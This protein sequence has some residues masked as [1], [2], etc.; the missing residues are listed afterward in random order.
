MQPFESPRELWTPTSTDTSQM[1][2]FMDLVNVKYGA[3]I[4]GSG[5]SNVSRARTMHPW[6]RSSGSIA[7]SKYTCSVW[8][9][10]IPSM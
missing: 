9:Y 10:S 6:I 7:G 3:S 5:V 1:K 4:L 2:K 8:Q